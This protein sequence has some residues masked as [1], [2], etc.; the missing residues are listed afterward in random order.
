MNSLATIR[1]ETEADYR[2]V[3]EINRSAFWNLYVPGCDEHYLAHILPSSPDF[4]PELALV[5]ELDSRIIGSILYTKA[6]L[7]DESGEEKP[8]L[9]FGPVCIVPELQRQ[10]YGKQLIE[11]SF[12]KAV[13][14]GAEVIV[15]FGN[16]G[17]YVSRGFV[18]CKRLNVCVDNGVFPAAMLV[19]ELK[20]GVLDGR[21]WMYCQTPSFTFDPKDAQRFD[22]GFEPLEKKTQPSQEEFYIHSHAI[23]P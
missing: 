4:V 10:G 6:R 15:I 8:I 3:E 9:T 22:E 12:E 20:P 21:R 23:L 13:A 16:P 1:R 19:K 17:N 18:S 11:A 14:L 2:Q 5:A 7:V